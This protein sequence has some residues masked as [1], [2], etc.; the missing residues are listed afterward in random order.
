MLGLYYNHIHNKYIY[1]SNLYTCIPTFALNNR[2]FNHFLFNGANVDLHVIY[3]ISLTIFYKFTVPEIHI[4][5]HKT[6]LLHLPAFFLII[7]ILSAI[8][9]FFLISKS[10]F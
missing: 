4:F 1:K 6:I 9:T 7:I 8:K 3:I 5:K 10:M 2:F